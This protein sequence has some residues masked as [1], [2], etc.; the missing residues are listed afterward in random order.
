MQARTN[1]RVARRGDG[2]RTCA[3]T[4]AVV[5]GYLVALSSNAWLLLWLIGPPDGNWTMHTFLF[6]FYISAMYLAL[7][8][9]YL[10]ADPTVVET[11]HTIFLF[12]F[13]AASV[14]LIA[15]CVAQGAFED[16]NR[17]LDVF[18][19]PSISFLPW[20]VTEAV[21]FF[22]FPQLFV[23]TAFTPPD[24][25]LKLTLELHADADSD[26]ESHTEPDR[27]LLQAAGTDTVTHAVTSLDPRAN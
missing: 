19:N 26:A 21:N 23:V 16:I 15:V 7:L 11:R 18:G 2:S 10:E 24:K 27:H 8:G 1:I 17:K 20:W 22:W 4:F 12:T 13:G 5:T 6:F 9:N 25:P 14:L 3:E